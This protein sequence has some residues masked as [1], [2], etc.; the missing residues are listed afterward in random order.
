M[1][2]CIIAVF[3]GFCLTCAASS[4]S[5]E[6]RFVQMDAT[7]CT[8]DWLVTNLLANNQGQPVML[9]RYSLGG[10]LTSPQF[11]VVQRALDEGTNGANPFVATRVTIASGQKA[12]IEMTDMATNA[13]KDILELNF[14]LIVTPN[15]STNGYDI[16]MDFIPLLTTSLPYI[17]IPPRPSGGIPL[18]TL[19]DVLQPA[20]VFGTPMSC[21]VWD[22]QTIV[23][24]HFR[25]HVF[26]DRKRDGHM[27]QLVFSEA[28]KKRLV[29]FVT[30][31]LVD[32]HG[33]RIHSDESMPMAQV[34]LPPQPSPDPPDFY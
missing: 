23:F 29:V 14:R 21:T 31:T 34:A 4:V 6:V 30:Q 11:Q 18:M 33:K 22:G 16:K 19:S 20:V 25:D 27:E 13:Q 15:V 1:K 12:E 24:G 26:V 32:E 8:F 28:R 3:G 17:K 5:I 7:N 9:A 10:I 2:K